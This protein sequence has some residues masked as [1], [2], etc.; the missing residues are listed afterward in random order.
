MDLVAKEANNYTHVF[1]QMCVHK[2]G[3]QSIL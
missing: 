1:K 2:N 3:E